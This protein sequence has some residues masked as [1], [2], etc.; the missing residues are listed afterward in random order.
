MTSRVRTANFVPEWFNLSKYGTAS[1]LDAFGWHIQLALRAHL[2]EGL[3]LPENKRNDSW[4]KGIALVRRTPIVSPEELF[5]A[6]LVRNEFLGVRLTSAREL[7][8][9]ERKI[10]KEK[11]KQAS[12]VFAEG[13]LDTDLLYAMRRDH[14]AYRWLDQPVNKVAG[15]VGLEANIR[16]N[17]LLPDKLILEQF[18]ALL[19]QLRSGELGV[20]LQMPHLTRANFKNWAKFSVLP[21]LDLDIWAQETGASIP[22][23]AMIDAI[24]EP[25]ERSVETLRKTTEKLAR[26]LLTWPYQ[27]T[28]AALAAQ[29]TWKKNKAI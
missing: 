6:G 27:K 8:H 14:A 7:Y 21:F 2:M 9:T 29:Q 17:L 22:R 28:L 26:E 20:G 24:F 25:L 4:R 10:P 19:Q 23:K 12:L 15:L 16:V 3:R 13:L 18:G 5:D 1:K 11:R